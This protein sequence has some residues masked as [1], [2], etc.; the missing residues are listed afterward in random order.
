MDKGGIMRRFLLMDITKIIQIT[1]LVSLYISIVMTGL[2][3]FYV[4][5]YVFGTIIL[6]FTVPDAPGLIISCGFKV[7]L[8]GT[9]YIILGVC[10]LS[11]LP[12]KVKKIVEGV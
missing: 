5:V 3:A 7:G 10:A 12:K 8:V 2:M 1:F 11:F 6:L 4:M 9:I